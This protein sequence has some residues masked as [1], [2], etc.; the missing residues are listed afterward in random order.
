[1]PNY[2]LVINS[3]FR[4]FSYQEMLAPVQASTEAHK[5][6]EEEYGNL[7]TQADV[8]KTLANEQ[9][10][11]DAY[12]QYMTYAND[13]Q[14]QADE[15][16][17][18][19]LN[20]TSRQSMLNMRKRYASEILPIE[21]AFK[22]REE[23]IKEQRAKG[24][25]TLNEFDA[26]KTSLDKYLHN[27]SLS[28]NTINLD[29][30][31]KQSVQVFSQYQNNFRNPDK[32]D[33]KDVAK[34]H[35]ALIKQHGFSADT[36]NAI[37]S[38]IMN[39][40]Y[41]TAESL[42]YKG[43]ADGIYNNTG[44]GSWN[45]AQ[46]ENAVLNEIARGVYTGMGKEDMQLFNNEEQ[47]QRDR[48][49]LARSAKAKE[50]EETTRLGLSSA[51][52]WDTSQYNETSNRIKK[53]KTKY[54]SGNNNAM[55]VYEYYNNADTKKA[56]FSSLPWVHNGAITEDDLNNAQLRNAIIGK[57][58]DRRRATVENF[59]RLLEEGKKVQIP[60]TTKSITE[61]ELTSAIKNDMNKYIDNAGSD[62]SK[63][64]LRSL[65]RQQIIADR[66]KKE[67]TWK[68]HVKEKFGVSDIISDKDYSKLQEM[69][70]QSNSNQ[71]DYDLENAINQSAQSHTMYGTHLTS[72]DYMQNNQL[73]PRINNIENEKDVRARI[74]KLNSDGTQ[75]EGVKKKDITFLDNKNKITDI[76]YSDLYKGK[77]IVEDNQGN[78]YIVDPKLIDDSVE[79]AINDMETQFAD[80]PTSERQQAIAFGLAELFNSFNQIQ[81][82]TSSNASE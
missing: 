37:A 20:P 5:A 73:I 24:N 23:H 81:S 78:R 7:S 67:T 34:Y 19:G 10:D 45:D 9:R 59:Y 58:R 51:S 57:E 47:L 56:F 6:I 4:P 64:L 61:K 22:R 30:V 55:K 66:D 15:L 52:F 11:P 80:D 71:W 54:G 74:Y 8:W 18:N 1:M 76:Y 79:R 21:N 82:K 13:L 16:A 32:F 43:I 75:G 49:A 48:I 2:N 26:S 25:R 17:M 14:A 33:V 31:Y 38:A 39:K 35:K 50:Q 40:D 63:S 60:G 36:A 41:S 27:P 72:Y 28:Y 77:I 12:Q 70:L 44:V 65:T 29:D 42:L 3:K 68:N 46:A 53:D 62:M 69:G